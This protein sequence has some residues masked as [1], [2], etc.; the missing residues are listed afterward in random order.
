MK[1][2]IQHLTIYSYILLTVIVLSAAVS[3]VVW[4]IRFPGIRRTFVYEST[5]S[6]SYSIESRYLVSNPE[7]GKIR[8][9]IDELL[10]GPISEH[11][12]PIFADGTRVLSCFRR[13]S[14]L[15]VELSDDF[16]H[17]DPEKTDFKKKLELFKRNIIRNFPGIK[18]VVVFAGGNELF[19]NDK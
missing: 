16:L 9:Y 11:C 15:Y 13:N 18:K 8:N 1:I 17:D 10:L 5:S 2:K 19:A 14:V 3:F 7:Q 6:D 12:R 4:T